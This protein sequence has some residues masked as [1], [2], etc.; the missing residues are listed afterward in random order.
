MKPI[1]K[2]AL[3]TRLAM[4]IIELARLENF[5]SGRHVTEQ[6]IADHFRVS[7]TPARKALH[8]LE[9]MGVLRS[10]K[11]RGFFLEKTG[12]AL[13]STALT[14]AQSDDETVYL[15]IAD[16][17]V[18]GKI[19][20]TLR[21]ADLM[22]RYSITRASAK[23]ILHRMARENLISPKSGRGWEFEPI[24]DSLDAHNQSYQFRMIIEPAAILDPGFK[25]NKSAFERSRQEQQAML[26]G[27]ILRL[28]RVQLFEIS[29]RFHEMIVGCASNRFLLDA[30]KRQNQLRRLI[31]YRASLDR[32]RFILQCQEHLTLLDVLTHGDRQSAA[33]FMR[34]HLDVVRSIKTAIAPDSSVA[35]K[36][37]LHAQF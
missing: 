7:R 15:Q 23:A 1:Y 12:K 32:S 21:E 30:L 2:S 25:I 13:R 17:R 22:R 35:A 6:F 4:Q 5:E 29:S 18:Q 33:G 27:G 31:E 9:E 28:S 14:S 20:K 8:F 19:G 34:N 24:L 37:K 36:V 3:T 26:D 16:D 10:E 11:N